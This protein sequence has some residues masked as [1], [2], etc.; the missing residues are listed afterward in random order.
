MRPLRQAMQHCV[1]HRDADRVWFTRARDIAEYC[2]K[3]PP[4][5]VPGS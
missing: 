4:G 3:L 5:V 1:G 2:F